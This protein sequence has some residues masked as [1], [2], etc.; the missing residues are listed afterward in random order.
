MRSSL[1]FPPVLSSSLNLEKFKSGQLNTRLAS[2]IETSNILLDSLN[3]P[4]PLRK[5][6]D[7]L[8]SVQNNNIAIC[9][10]DS[11]FDCEFEDKSDDDSQDFVYSKSERTKSGKQDLATHKDAQ[12]KL[13]NNEIESV[14]T[15]DEQFQSRY[16]PVCCLKG[17]IRN[18]SISKTTS[19]NFTKTQREP[20]KER[21]LPTEEGRRSCV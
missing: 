19:N 3:F 21:E 14:S 5:S 18:R 2:S 9:I 8:D 13:E 16:N 15:Q 17:Q 20:K 7:P 10:P 12:Y 11:K 1:Q 4:S 6:Q